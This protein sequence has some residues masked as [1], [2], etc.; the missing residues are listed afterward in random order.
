[1][2]QSLPEESTE[3]RVSDYLGTYERGVVRLDAPVD[4]KDGTRVVVSVAEPAGDSN[5]E[6][7]PV[8][9]VGFGL[10][11]RWVA[12]I[13]ERHKVDYVI[14]DQNPDT[15]EMQKRLGLRAIAGDISQEE[16]LR[17]A[18]IEDASLL[19]LTI[20]DEQA[21]LRATQ[22]A[23]RLKPDIYIVARTTYTSAGLKAV[24]L[25]ANEVI[26]GEQAVARQFY[27]KLMRKLGGVPAK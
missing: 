24:Q 14:V 13:F 11:G 10:A 5:G 6:L 2:S 19:V 4:W 26:K 9:L 21:V 3:D 17:K 20:P 16:T 22:L 23:R 1:M 25:G 12:D 8:I 27:E 7:G 18:G 15:V